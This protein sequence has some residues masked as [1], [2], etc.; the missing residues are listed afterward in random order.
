MAIFRAGKRLGPFDLRIG[1]PRGRE[2]D[3]FEVPPAGNPETTI[4]RFRA[5]IAKGEGLARTNKFLVRVNAPQKLELNKVFN[6]ILTNSF[7][8]KKRNLFQ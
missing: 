6:N 5:A 2:Y 3:K 8:A 7:S 1:L 4:N